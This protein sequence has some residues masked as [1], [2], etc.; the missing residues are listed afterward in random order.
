MYAD[1]MGDWLDHIVSYTT[2]GGQPASFDHPFAR[3]LLRET[4]SSDTNR[5]TV[6]QAARFFLNRLGDGAPSEARSI[7]VVFTNGYRDA[8]WNEG[9][10]GLL[11]GALEDIPE[12]PDRLRGWLGFSL[13][14][15]EGPDASHITLLG[16]LYQG[17]STL[18]VF[19]DPLPSMIRRKSPEELAEVIEGGL[20]PRARR[21]WRG[22]V[23]HLD[24]HGEMNELNGLLLLVHRECRDRIGNSRGAMRAGISTQIL[25]ALDQSRHVGQPARHGRFTVVSLDDSVGVGEVEDP[26]APIPGESVDLSRAKER[27]DART[28]EILR[29]YYQA[30]LDQA[31]I[32]EQLGITQARVSQILSAACK[33]LREQL[34]P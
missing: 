12:K 24:R 11:W 21:R 26:S 27:L 14:P 2:N 31:E 8:R 5:Q 32:G 18:L 13:L 1:G 20:P 16:G 3:P 6:A 7:Q 30:D 22:L 28:R 25:E 9:V 17:A 29:L 4:D 33:V 19:S 15:D 23:R 10:R 34:L